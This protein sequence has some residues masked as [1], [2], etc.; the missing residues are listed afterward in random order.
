MGSVAVA[1]G[2]LVFLTVVA[3]LAGVFFI[4]NPWRTA[5]DRLT[6]MTGSAPAQDARRSER[7]G[8]VGQTIARLAAP[9]EDSDDFN[10]LRKRLIQ[11]GYRGRNNVE[12][13]SA[14][15]F[16]LAVAF[17]LLFAILPLQTGTLGS[18]A[19]ALVTCAVGYWLP[20]LW[21]T[22]TLQK[23]QDAI[24]RT[25]PDALD[26]LTASVEA[27]LGLDA[28]FRRVANEMGEAAPLLCDELKLVNNEVS[29]GISRTEALRHLEVR[30]G[31]DEVASLVNVLIQAERFGTPVARSLR[32]HSE[33]VR[34]KR[35]QK[36][37]EAAAKISP[38]L[39]VAMI[40]FMLPCLI[41][42]VLGPAIVK[43]IRNLLPALGG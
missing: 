38:K 43:V 32:V 7:M 14:I 19:G 25:F 41:I 34:T 28:A 31:L 23:R 2:A 12:L 10:A 17:P 1:A 37:E 30:T 24:L 22:N 16:A 39:T 33:L 18:V 29:A 21:V 13:Y 40:L 6:D 15:R 35:M 27:G 11:S 42:V 4:V 9:K 3:A 36:A 20:A 5:Q 8:A 26:M